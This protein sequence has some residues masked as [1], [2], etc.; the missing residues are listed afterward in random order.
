MLIVDLA[1]IIETPPSNT[2]IYSLPICTLDPPHFSPQQ[3]VLGRRPQWLKCSRQPGESHRP[4]RSGQFGRWAR[5][6]PLLYQ[7]RGASPNTHR[8]HLPTPPQRHFVSSHLDALFQWY[9]WWV[10][11]R[12]RG[13]G[14]HLCRCWHHFRQ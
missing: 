7:R 4:T 11:L 6:G 9:R 12:R 13:W 14:R 1:F 3:R 10:R 5:A 8:G 2:K